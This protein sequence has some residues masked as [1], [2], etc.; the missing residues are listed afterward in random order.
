MTFSDRPARRVCVCDSIRVIRTTNVR[1]CAGREESQAMRSRKQRCPR[2]ARMGAKTE[3]PFRS[4]TRFRFAPIGAHWRHS[5]ARDEPHFSGEGTLRCWTNLSANV[6]NV[7][8]LKKIFRHPSRQHQSC[9]MIWLAGEARAGISVV[10]ISFT[11]FIR[12]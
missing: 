12:R 9:P 5:R 6:D 7:V 1:I 4:Q 11:L 2:M 3:L 10:K 8:F